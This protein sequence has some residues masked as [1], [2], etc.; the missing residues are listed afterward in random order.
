MRLRKNFCVFILS[1]GR[2]DNIKTLKTLK[3]AN[4]SGDWFIIDSDDDNHLKEYQKNLVLIYVC[5]TKKKKVNI[6]I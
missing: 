5:L 6:L 1:Y 2:P 3:K 4:Y